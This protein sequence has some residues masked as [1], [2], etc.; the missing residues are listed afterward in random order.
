MAYRIGMANR[1]KSRKSRPGSR[2]S[3]STTPQNHQ[4]TCISDLCGELAQVLD[5]RTVTDGGHDTAI[6]Q[7]KLYRFSN[8]TESAQMLQQPAVYVVAQGRKEVTV[9]D[10]TYIYDPSQYLAVSLE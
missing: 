7:L 2:G 10:E 5:R 9:G 3:R 1:S 4:E 8:P 6:P